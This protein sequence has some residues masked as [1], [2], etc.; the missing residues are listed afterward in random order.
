[1]PYVACLDEHGKSWVVDKSDPGWGAAWR[2]KMKLLLDVPVLPRK[3]IMTGLPDPAISSAGRQMDDYL[4]ARRQAGSEVLQAVWKDVSL[5]FR[6]WR[7]QAALFDDEPSEQLDL[8]LDG[9]DRE[10]AGQASSS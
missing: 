10:R 8:A 7:T 5:R 1:M 4:E 2:A 6:A 3:L 9:E